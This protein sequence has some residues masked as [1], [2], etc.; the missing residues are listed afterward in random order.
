M[1][2]GRLF[3]SAPKWNLKDRYLKYFRIN[4]GSNIADYHGGWQK[5]SG[6][7]SDLSRESSILWSPFAVLCSPI[8][9][10]HLVI[11]MIFVI[12]IIKLR[13]F[14]ILPHYYCHTAVGNVGVD[15]PGG[16]LPCRS[17]LFGQ[18]QIA[19]MTN[20]FVRVSLKMAKNN[21]RPRGHLQLVIGGLKKRSCFGIAVPLLSPGA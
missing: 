7:L 11:T 2:E 8:F 10:I 16:V 1:K 3:H 12:S 19:L 9:D 18:L 6:A 13:Q 4:F 5:V 14:P 17:V 20:V 21:G 15:R